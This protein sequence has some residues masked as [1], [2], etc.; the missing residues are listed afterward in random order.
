MNNHI[1]L[2]TASRGIEARR[3][4]NT[5]IANLCFGPTRYGLLRFNGREYK[6]FSVGRPQGLLRMS[7][8]FGIVA[9]LYF[10]GMVCSLPAWAQQ[11]AGQ[12]ERQKGTAS[13]ST[14][15]AT[16]DLAQGSQVFVG[17]EIRTGPGARLLIQFDDESKLTLGENARITIDQF[18]YEPAGDSNQALAIVVGV[19]R[20]ISGRIAN[21]SPLDVAFSTPVATIGLRGTEFLGGELTVGMPVGQPHYGFQINEGAI[22]V[23]SP[24]GSVVL[25]EA[26]EGTFLPLTGIAAPTPVRQWTAEEAAEAVDALAF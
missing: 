15:S 17:D 7:I 25:D 23:I 1:G 21:E 9:A 5:T 24:G 8:N 13:R 14:A 3:L 22:E 2:K 12:V 11:A 19:F 16:S 4:L 26:G 20:F 18:V 6:M 10:L